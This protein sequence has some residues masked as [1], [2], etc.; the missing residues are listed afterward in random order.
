[1]KKEGYDVIVIDGVVGCG[2]STL[3]EILEKEIGVE[4]YPE[5]GSKDTLNLLDRFYA[6]KTRWAFT[7]QVHFLNTRFAQIKEIHRSGG[8]ILDR[9]IFGDRIFA[10]M[11]AE[12]LEDGGAGMTWE[13]FRTYDTLLDSMLEHAQA[14]TLLIYLECDVDTAVE[15]IA[16]RN[17][18]I[19]SEVER[20]YWER[21]NAKYQLWYEKY[22]ASPKIKINVANLNYVDN[23]EDRKKVVEIVKSEL[24]KIG[25]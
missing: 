16:K 24:A 2:K 18:G 10:E 19:E 13:E 4:M 11:L 6:K 3:A 22:N 23:E 1:M 7:T 25:R 17:R 9:S 20:G 8:G 14:P 15:R 12:D 21:L 5:I